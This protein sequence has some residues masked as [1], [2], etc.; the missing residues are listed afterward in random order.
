MIRR[1][2]ERDRAA[3]L[4]IVNDAAHAYKG[5]I[6]DDCWH[7]PYMSADELRSEI[8]S[9][10]EFW[11]D[12]VGGLM[13]G[14]M[15]L[16]QVG[17]VTLI[18]HTYVRSADQGHGIGGALLEHLRHLTVRPMLVG[19]WRD[20]SWAV[21]FY[22]RRGFQVVPREQVPALLRRY[23]SVPERQ[24]AASVVLADE[25]WRRGLAR[26]AWPEDPGAIL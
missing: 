9:G 24:I 2:E 10:I 4:E 15:G 18:R 20:A 26:G 19:T 25:R 7:E 1:C 11:A 23:W 5:V 12:E 8:G 14:V 21:R 13:R 17:D 16:Q 6:P 22:E 3:I